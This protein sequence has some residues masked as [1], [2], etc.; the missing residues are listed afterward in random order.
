MTDPDAEARQ[1]AD[2][3]VATVLT[4][5]SR[6][7]AAR[8]LESG[9]EGLSLLRKQIED[10]VADVVTAPPHDTPRGHDVPAEIVEKAKRLALL[11]VRAALDRM[12]AEL[13]ADDA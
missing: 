5:I 7:L 6:D 11:R 3:L 13:T 4:H 9:S 1:I 2:N 12:I 10:V 8:W